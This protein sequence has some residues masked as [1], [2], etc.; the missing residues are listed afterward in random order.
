M[1][2]KPDTQTVLQSQIDVRNAFP[3]TSF[4]PVISVETLAEFG[5]FPLGTAN[6]PADDITKNVSEGAPALVNGAWQITYVATDASA[7]EIAARQKALVPAYV[8]MRQAR[9]ALAAAGKLDAVAAAIAGMS[10]PAKT[11]ATIDWEYSQ[12]VERT[13]PLVAAL[14][15]ALGLTD[16]QI[17]QLFITAQGL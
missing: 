13:W 1:Y 4:P 2:Y 7:E 14:A 12:I 15:P 6:K 16:A 9:R 3:N 8:T 17:D 11:Q 5:V 10:E